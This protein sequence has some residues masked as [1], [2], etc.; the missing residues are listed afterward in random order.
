MQAAMWSTRSQ[1]KTVRRISISEARRTQVYRS[2]IALS[3]FL[4]SGHLGTTYLY[5]I[6]R[7]LFESPVAWYSASHGYD[8]KPGLEDMKQ[9]PPPLSIQSSCLRCHMSAVQPTDPGTVNRY[10]GA[11]FPSWRHHMRVMPWKWATTCEQPWQTAHHESGT[12]SPSAARFG[13]YQ[14]PSGRGCLCGAGGALCA[15]LPSR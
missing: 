12:Y 14:L 8:M 6:N 2:G 5:A 9:I 11:A 13:V 1:T 7:Y 15:E 3:Y 10:A 4:G